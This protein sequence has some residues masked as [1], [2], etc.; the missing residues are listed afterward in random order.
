MGTCP[1][2]SNQPMLKKHDFLHH[3]VTSLPYR[4]VLALPEALSGISG[5]DPM[6]EDLE[7]QAL[8]TVLPPQGYLRPHW[9]DQAH[10]GL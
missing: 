6:S 8:A 1:L 4:P 2:P 7:A 9:S 10:R 5:Y 3:Y